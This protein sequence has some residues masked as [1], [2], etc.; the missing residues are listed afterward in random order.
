MKFTCRKQHSLILIIASIVAACIIVAVALFTVTGN[1]FITEFRSYVLDNEMNETI[2]AMNLFDNDMDTQKTMM[3][4]ALLDSENARIRLLYSSGE[5][6]TSYRDAVKTVQV[7]L[8]TMSN[9]M[10]F[11]NDVEIYFLSPQMYISP[12]TAGKYNGEMADTLRQR[13]ENG[14]PFIAPDGDRLIVSVSASSGRGVYQTNSIITSSISRLTFTRYLRQFSPDSSRSQY[15]VLVQNGTQMEP[16]AWV[17][18]FLSQAELVRF[19]NM[20]Q[21]RQPL[22]VETEHGSYLL[23]SVESA[24]GPIRLCQITPLSML[25]N[26]VVTYRAVILGIC[27]ASTLLIALMGGALFIMI[28]Q[29]LSRIQESIARVEN[30]DFTTRVAPTWSREFQAMFDHF[31]KMTMRIRQL[32]DRECELQRLNARAEIKQL[33][34][35]INPHFLYN[36]YFILRAML[37]DEDYESALEMSDLLGQYMRYITNPNPGYATLRDEILHSSQYMRIQQIRFANRIE[38]REE[39]CPESLL[40]LRVPRL[41]LQPLIENAFEHG[42][43]QRMEGGILYLHY[44]CE[45][46]ALEIFVEDNG[47]ATDETIARVQGMLADEYLM[48]GGETV[49]LANITRRLRLIYG[50]DGI[51][52]VFRSALGG[53]CAKIRIGGI[54]QNDPSGFD[55]RR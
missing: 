33:Q 39:A 10:N 36:S 11:A 16:F 7:L 18:N 38:I 13:L 20:A 29:P 55:R 43:K 51:L 2:V 44:R 34:Y 37:I 23:T 8:S 25:E 6:D 54:I 22:T 3:Y 46:D 1:Y 28:K 21:D 53:F 45:A 5:L 35:Q 48:A 15:A 42:L 50:E 4:S 12:S 31:N 19:C 32:I 24:Q 9:V 52:Q 17:G 47:S 30:G 49:A 40:D 27:I 14:L 41:I 26:Q